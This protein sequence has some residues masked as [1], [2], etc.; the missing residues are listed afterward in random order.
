MCSP[1]R[2]VLRM[3]QESRTN[4]QDWVT[5]LRGDDTHC[6]LQSRTHSLL[7]SLRWGAQ[8]RVTKNSPGAAQCSMPQP[9]PDLKCAWL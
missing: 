4:G 1:S 7:S 6:L 8:V 9:G 2:L 3:C 5:P